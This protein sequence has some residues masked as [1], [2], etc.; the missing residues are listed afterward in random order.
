MSKLHKETHQ[1]RN[2]GV[3]RAAVLGA[4]DGIVSTASLLVGV[5]SAGSSH[6][7]VVVAGLAGLVAGAMSMAAGEY[8][9]VSSQA[10]TEKASLQLEYEELQADP[11][12]EIN[13]LCLIYE[14]RGLDH[15][16]AQ[17]VAVKLTEHDAWAS[18][19]RDELGY[20]SENKARPLKAAITSFVMFAIGATVP[21]IA[22]SMT[23]VTEIPSTISTVSLLSLAILGALSAKA[24]GAPISKAVL[25]VVL[26]GAMAIGLTACVGKLFGTTI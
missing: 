1:N 15:A 4:D 19:A 8:V 5:A 17:Q 7:D 25:R 2:L 11:V 20:S 26:W 13:E 21:L 22:A 18:H 12:G 24:G 23:Q 3:L 9:S 14:K 6:H 10:D 16:L